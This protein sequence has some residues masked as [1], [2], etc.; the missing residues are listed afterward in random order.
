MNRPL[1]PD[2]EIDALTL[3]TSVGTE[4]LYLVS[5]QSCWD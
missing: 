1:D 4:L 2:L 5:M 3:Y